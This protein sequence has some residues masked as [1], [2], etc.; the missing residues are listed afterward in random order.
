MIKIRSGAFSATPLNRASDSTSACRAS[1]RRSRRS[2]T[3]PGASA[4]R[5]PQ[6]GWPRRGSATCP[7][8]SAATGRGPPSSRRRT[9]EARTNQ[10]TGVRD[11]SRFTQNLGVRIVK[12]A[13]GY[14]NRWIIQLN[15]FKLFNYK[16]VYN[17]HT[18]PFF[19]LFRGTVY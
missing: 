8:C 2:S 10:L 6:A 3:V 1:M 19:C 14:F 16:L 4:P 11:L 9:G 18:F 15:V 12:T 13:P 17:Q 7:T 5:S